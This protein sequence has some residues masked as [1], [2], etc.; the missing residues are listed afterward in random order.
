MPVF[1]TQLEGDTLML[2]EAETSGAF[3]KSDLEIRPN[4]MAA[5]DN[6]IAAMGTIGRRIAS[7]IRSEYDGT[8]IDSAEVT[9]GVKVDQAGAVMIAQENERSQFTV[10]LHV[11]TQ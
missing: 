10:K 4:P 9:F 7:A 8:G 3:A 6:S 2:I 5:F 1:M 11:R